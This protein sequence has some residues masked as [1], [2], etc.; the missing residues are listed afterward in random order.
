MSLKGIVMAGGMG[1]RLRPITYSIPKPVVPIAGKP[2]MSYLL[3]SFYNAGIKDI[4][5]TTGYK[6]SSLISSVIDNRYNDQTVLFS[7]E[8]EPAGTAGGIKL[9]SNFI[10]ETFIVGSGDILSDF[11]IADIIKFHRSKKALITIVLKKVPDPSQ[12]GI[13]EVVDDKIVR[14]LEKPGENEAFS[15]VVNTGIYVMEP[16]IL[17][18]IKSIP[19]DFAKDLFPRLMRKN[20]DIYGYVGDGVWLDT[21]RPNDLIKANQI[22]INKYGKEYNEGAFKGKNI[23]VT[24]S[25][26]SDAN[27]QGC[28]IG[29]GIQVGKGSI[30]KD[31]AVYDNVTLESG[32]NI[33]SSLL[34]DNV[35]I[36]ANSKIKNSVIMKNCIIGEDSEIVDSIIAPDM[37]LRGKSRIYNVSLAS[38]IIED[39][40]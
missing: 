28:Y 15:N 16:E 2:C 27:I 20:I 17:K 40:R 7:V 13:V 37:D 21:G 26:F 9:I 35:T 38:K 11:N 30:I 33:A 32:V 10:D 19:Y 29:N 24:M 23:I 25:R 12:F 18:Y 39:E 5:V 6:F 8:K 36:K 34:M 31:S 22:M 3:D 14:F 4:V 1:T